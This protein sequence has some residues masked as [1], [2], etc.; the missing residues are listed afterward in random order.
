[1][2]VAW[3]VLAIA[4]AAL[5]KTPAAKA[6][7][8]EEI[9]PMRLREAVDL[10]LRKCPSI[11]VPFEPNWR[12]PVCTWGGPPVEIDRRPVPRGATRSSI[13]VEPVGAD[14]RL[15]HIKSEVTSIVRSVE[16]E[17][18]HLA[19][20]HVALWAAD[21]A[22]DRARNLIEIE[23]TLGDPDCPQD[24]DDLAATQRRLKHLEKNLLAR[25]AELNAAERGFQ[26]MLGLPASDSR[27]IVP[28]TPPT[29][30]PL[31]FAWNTCLDN[32]PSNHSLVPRPKAFCCSPRPNL[33]AALD[34]FDGIPLK[35]IFC[36]EDEVWLARWCLVL[37]P[38][39]S[40]G[41]CI[42]GE[43]SRLPREP[44][45]LLGKRA[46]QSPP[47][48]GRAV[49]EAQSSYKRYAATKYLQVTA[50]AQLEAQRSLWCRGRI[51]PDSYLDM[52][53]QFTRATVNAARELHAFNLAVSAVKQIQGTLLEQYEIIVQE[54]A[55]QHPTLATN[56]VDSR[57]IPINLTEENIQ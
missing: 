29:E 36:I 1:M 41:S 8:P 28:I 40:S 38:P 13:V 54:P 23:E 12:L 43:P 22:V 24:L 27:R 51:S 4:S 53:E 11:R 15:P 56:Q 47:S 49:L 46:R 48:F 7:E 17:Y 25:T 6:C 19:M 9:W 2:T 37:P 10:G 30:A 42:Y 3:C 5:D 16:R 44:L 35:Q 55:N 20:R 32:V 57:A 14:A 33:I 26:A 34:E 45:V 31:V 21:R 18:G 52:I 50:E 39:A